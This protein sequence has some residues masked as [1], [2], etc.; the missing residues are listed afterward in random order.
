MN[1]INLYSDKLFNK[2][3]IVSVVGVVRDNKGSTALIYKSL[4]SITNSYTPI[5]MS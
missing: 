4:L 2:P 1:N 3:Y 5:C